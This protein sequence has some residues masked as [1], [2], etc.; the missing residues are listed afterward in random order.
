MGSFPL[1]RS[2]QG[3]DCSDFRKLLVSFRRHHGS[4]LFSCSVVSDSLW[5]QGLQW[6]QVLGVEDCSVPG[7]PVHHQLPELTQTHILWI[8]DA[9][10]PSHPLSSPSPPAFNLSQHQGLFQWVSS[11]HQVTKTLE[12]QLQHQL[13]CCIW[14]G[15]SVFWQLVVPLYCGGSSLWVGL[16][17]WLVKVSCL[18]KLA[19][20]FWWVELDFSPECN[21]VSSSEFWDVYG[22]AVNLGS[23]YIEAQ[24]YVPALLENLR[25][26]SC[27]GTCWLLGGAWFQCRYGG[28]WMSSCPLMFPGVR[29][30]LV[31]SGFELK[32]PVSGFPS[33]S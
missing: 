22:F 31:F 27:S 8:G 24:G 17:E 12:F 28:F 16:Y 25:C 32:P 33:Y 7:L 18:G 20:L 1:V 26:M 29:S 2:K 10:Q 14:G 6:P 21:E 13:D 15:L 9:I 23:L 4:V 30:S 3:E 11:L 19:S 5:P